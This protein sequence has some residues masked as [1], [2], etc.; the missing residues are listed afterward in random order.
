MG[1][2]K[3]VW[4]GVIRP[5]ALPARSTFFEELT[6]NSLILPAGSCRFQYIR[7]PERPLNAFSITSLFDNETALAENV[8]YAMIS[9]LLRQRR[10]HGFM[11][12]LDKGNPFPLREV[13]RILRF[14]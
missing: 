7:G 8:F 9:P 10:F 6:L 13:I 5:L 3:R 4:E 2:E 14:P 11:H 12:T 1:F